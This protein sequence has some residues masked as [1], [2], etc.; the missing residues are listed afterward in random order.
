MARPDDASGFDADV[1]I[2]GYG[3]S[4]VSAANFLG[5][6]GVKVI[7]LERDSDIYQRARAVTVNDW[8]L[9]CFQSVG[10][11]GA[12]R[13]DM[14]RTTAL[15][16][17]TYAR[18]E[19]I[20]INFTESTLGQ[21]SSSMIY[22]PVFEQT[23]REGAAR[24]SEHVQVRYGQNVTGIAQD[25]EGVSLTA[26]H[27]STGASS[28]I[29]AK[30]VL[31]CDGG[32]SGIRS[33]LGIKLLGETIETKWV[34]ID[35]RVKRWWA[36]R[37]LLTFWSDKNR[38]VVDIPLSM[39]NHRWEFPLKSHE[40]ESDFDSPEKL[41]PLINS[42]GVTSE[43]VELHQHA[44]YKHH[45][46]RAE[47]WQQG[48]VFLVGDAAHLMPPWAGS[49]MQSGIRDAFNL[50]WKLREVLAGRLPD[51]LL[52]TY[53]PER[54]PSVELAT[55]TSEQLGRIIKQEMRR[56][57]K[58]QAMVGGVFHKLHLPMPPSPLALPPVLNTGWLHGPV[59]KTSAIG[60]MLPQ[61]RIATAAGQRGRLDDALGTGFV[62]LGD[63]VNPVLLLS[64]V[65]KSAWDAL[66]ARYVAVRACDQSALADS[67][68]MDL[69]GSLL[70]WLR[71]YKASA[72]ALRPDRFVAAAHSE[73]FGTRL[74][75]P[76]ERK[77]NVPC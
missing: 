31:A 73:A 63:G 39:G 60:R 53:E 30:Y 42:M 7:A 46:R 13:K 17:V 16:W 69:E 52:A 70:V 35:A 62:L 12:L 43:H 61:P 26:N 54:A 14:D 19:L 22:Q 59:A 74:V 29:R 4:G 27:A 68:L 38:P 50:A 41:W 32:G 57:E 67:D 48:R 8:T 56:E 2:V 77:S 18:K 6:Y 47:R 34:V 25:A 33:E 45:L 3:P 23:L 36:D 71:K 11:D 76:G 58:I 64:P 20:R 65:E 44:F 40:S 24:F 15:R 37:H 66:G 9:R 51:S 5:A 1:A 10:L 21:P 72:I 75:V 49:G 55:Q 28:Q